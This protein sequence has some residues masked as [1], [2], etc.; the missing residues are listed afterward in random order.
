MA[1][2]SRG[3]LIAAGWYVLPDPNNG[4]GTA[5]SSQQGP[6]GGLRGALRLEA[7]YSALFWLE[8]GCGVL[9]FQAE[10]LQRPAAPQTEA[11]ATVTVSH[12]V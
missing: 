10:F 5:L 2:V 6:W 8:V 9:F 4:P 3:P 11:S 12:L 7:A 1:A